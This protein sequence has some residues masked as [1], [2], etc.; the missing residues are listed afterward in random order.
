[1]TYLVKNSAFRIKQTPLHVATTAHP[2]AELSPLLRPAEFNDD[3]HTG[4]ANVLAEMLQRLCRD[5][6]PET[7]GFGDA[8]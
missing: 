2:P 8:G 5:S 6:A 4:V 3:T 1:M 7:P